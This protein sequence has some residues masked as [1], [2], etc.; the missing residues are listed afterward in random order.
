ML[1][2]CPQLVQWYGTQPNNQQV[3]NYLIGAQ[4][5]CGTRSIA[6]NPLVC[7]SSPVSYQLPSQTRPPVQTPAP[8]PAP[9]PPTTTEYV[10]SLPPD[11][12]APWASRPVALTTEPVRVTPGPTTAAPITEAPSRS[13]DQCNDPKGVPGVCM[14]IRECPHI[15][16]EFVARQKDAAYIDYIRKSNVICKGA[17][18]VVCCTDLSRGTNG[19]QNNGGPSLAP[20]L[21]TIE[22]GCGFS[23]VTHT[24]VVGGRPAKKGA[25][26]W[27][28][29]IGYTNNF[30]EVGW[31]CGGSLITTRHVLTAA[32]CIKSTL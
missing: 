3:I 11:S 14:S 25:Y 8:T 30:G 21:L 29:L 12:S 4:R 26:P 22:E 32:H 16:A 20:R 5:N 13:V 2:Q 6:R 7:C 17:S 31:K 9:P 27:M 10:P 15:K 28:A 24:R 18:A 23:N 1:P 19:N